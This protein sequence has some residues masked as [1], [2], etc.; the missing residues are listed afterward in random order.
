MAVMSS[1][2]KASDSYRLPPVDTQMQHDDAD[3]IPQDVPPSYE[4]ATANDLIHRTASV[5]GI[6]LSY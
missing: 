3:P 2:S 6:Y 1:S 4:M 5:R